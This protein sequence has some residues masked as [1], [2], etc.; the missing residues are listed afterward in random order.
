VVVDKPINGCTCSSFVFGDADN[1]T[2]ITLAFPI[3][4]LRGG[5]LYVVT[6]RHDSG[7]QAKMPWWQTGSYEGVCKTF[8]AGIISPYLAAANKNLE[9]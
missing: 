6:S 1:Q 8:A 5:A 2:C 9:K 4:E 7:D 3:L